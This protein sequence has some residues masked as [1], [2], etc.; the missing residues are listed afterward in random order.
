M[1]AHEC[2]D[3]TSCFIGVHECDD[4]ISDQPGQDA[5]SITQR[6]RHTDLDGFMNFY[7]KD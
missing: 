5:N 1:G 6:R 3:Q 7:F 4:Q 2:D